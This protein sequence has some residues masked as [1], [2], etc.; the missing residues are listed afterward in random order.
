MKRQLLDEITKGIEKNGYF[1]IS[2]AAIETVL[3]QG[4]RRH[5]QSKNEIFEWA[6]ESGIKYE[7]KDGENGNI[8]RF[9]S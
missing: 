6:D 5:P 7:Y 2:E 3:Q 4:D 8:I 9:S 1:E